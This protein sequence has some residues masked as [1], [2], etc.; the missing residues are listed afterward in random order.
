MAKSPYV[1]CVAMLIARM[2][3]RCKYHLGNSPFILDFAY[4][5]RTFPSDTKMKEQPAA[6]VKPSKF[7]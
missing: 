3:N 2:Y 7:D 6:R 4:I 1:I 5:S